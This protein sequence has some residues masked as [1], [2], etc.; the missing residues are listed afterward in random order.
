[1]LPVGHTVASIVGI[2]GAGHDGGQ[3]VGVADDAAIVV[4]AVAV[5]IERR[6][7]ATRRANTRCGLGYH[8]VGDVVAVVVGENRAGYSTAT[9]TWNGQAQLLTVAHIVILVVP[10]GWAA[11]GPAHLLSLDS[12]IYPKLIF[13]FF[14]IGVL[15][16]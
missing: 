16:L 15:L 1:M 5:A 7:R 6:N 8:M 2:G 9:A 4:I 13:Y 11:T 12:K 3:S 14:A 10:H